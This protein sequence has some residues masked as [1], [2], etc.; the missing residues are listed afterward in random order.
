MLAGG[1]GEFQW[2]A[3]GTGDQG[4]AL[5]DAGLGAASIAEEMGLSPYMMLNH[6]VK[7]RR[8]FDVKL[9]IEAG[10]VETRLGILTLGD[11]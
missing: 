5:L 3:D 1:A 9:S 10:M 8:E 6:S 2:A 11:R 7:L 4:A